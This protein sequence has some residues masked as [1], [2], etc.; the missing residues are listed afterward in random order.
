MVYG[1]LWLERY[2]K[3]DG[4]KLIVYTLRHSAKA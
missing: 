1:P 2:A 4:R 3:D